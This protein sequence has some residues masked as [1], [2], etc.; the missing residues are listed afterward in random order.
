[1]TTLTAL[2]MWVL[3]STGAMDYDCYVEQLSAE[4]SEVEPPPPPSDTTSDGQCN[5]TVLSGSRVLGSRISNG[6]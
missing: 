2:F 1:M 5:T 3:V 6:I 4:S